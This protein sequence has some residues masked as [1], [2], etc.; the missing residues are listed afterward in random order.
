MAKTRKA[1]VN[2]GKKEINRKSVRVNKLLSSLYYDVNS[3][4]AYGEKKTF[5]EMQNDNFQTL[6]VPK[7]TNGSQNR[8]LIL[9]INQLEK[10][11]KETKQL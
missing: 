11:L 1:P 8:R 9:Y 10:T 5:I 3:A 2:R 7:S 6:H 4:S